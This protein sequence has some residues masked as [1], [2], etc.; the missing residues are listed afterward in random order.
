MPSPGPETLGAHSQAGGLILWAVCCAQSG[1]PGPCRL[2]KG[3]QQQPPFRGS[4][5]L[6]WRI[7]GMG[8]PGRLQSMGSLELDTTERLHFHF[9]VAQNPCPEHRAPSLSPE[10][11]EAVMRARTDPLSLG[12]LRLPT[13]PSL[14]C[15]ESGPLYGPTPASVPF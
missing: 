7:P 1:Q 8:E 14:L 12:L 13:G 2:P 9:P 11:W 10:L 15:H 5:V 3:T 4:S 6:T